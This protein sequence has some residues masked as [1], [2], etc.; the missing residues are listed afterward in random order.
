[1]LQQFLI[2]YLY[3]DTFKNIFKYIFDNYNLI[4]KHVPTILPEVQY[5]TIIFMFNFLTITITIT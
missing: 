3:V 4:Q 2:L 5:A 1:M